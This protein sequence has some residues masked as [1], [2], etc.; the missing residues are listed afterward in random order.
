MIKAVLFDL[1]GTVLSDEDEYGKA[2]KKV[3]LGLGKKVKKKYPHIGGIGVKENWPLLLSKYHIKTKRT[4]DELTHE[5][6]KAYLEQLTKITFKKG[7]KRFLDE[8]KSKGIKTALATSNSL[9]MV[10]QLSKRFELEQYFDIVTTEEEVN[11]NKP[12]PDI[13]RITAEKLGVDPESCIVIE[14]SKAG[15][16]AAH[17][18]GMRVVGMARDNKHSQSLKDVELVVRNFNE[19][20]SEKILE[21]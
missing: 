12:A 18:A 8:L 10:E 1:N 16:E 9:W 14:D 2:F 20:S 21:L 11:F 17:T 4:L 19:L 15:V 3:L 7:F 5:T 6:Q 13:F